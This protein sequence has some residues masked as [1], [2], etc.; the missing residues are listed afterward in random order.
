M[1]M[2]TE[3]DKPRMTRYARRQ[4]RMLQYER[5]QAERA[6]APEQPKRK[7]GGRQPGSGQPRLAENVERTTITLPAEL[8]NSLRGLGR[9][10]KLSRGVRTLDHRHRQLVEACR[11]LLADVA[12]RPGAY[13]NADKLK[14]DQIAALIQQ[15]DA[16]PDIH[17]VR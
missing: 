7:V 17:E 3:A 4:A 15:E 16:P 14:L 11:D 1:V 6:A 8:A 9:G 10:G 2:E 13:L 5:A 12:S